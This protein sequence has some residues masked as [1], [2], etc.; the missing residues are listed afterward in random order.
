[1]VFFKNSNYYFWH[2]PNLGF[3]NDYNWSGYKY[4]A[5]DV[6]ATTPQKFNFIIHT[7]RDT[8]SKKDIQTRPNL[9]TKLAIP[10]SWYRAQLAGKYKNTAIESENLSVVKGIGLS[11]ENPVGYPLIETRTISLVNEVPGDAVVVQQTK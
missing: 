7:D 9:W 8:L 4:I 3:V 11:M 1:M 6:Y 2:L 5:L 10:L